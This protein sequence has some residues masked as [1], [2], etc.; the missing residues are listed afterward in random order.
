MSQKSSWSRLCIK[1]LSLSCIARSPSAP[2]RLLSI[3]Q[4]RVPN[5]NRSRQGALSKVV[6]VYIML[7]SSPSRAPWVAVRASSEAI[8]LI[9]RYR[10]HDRNVFPPPWSY[11]SRITTFP[12]SSVW[13]LVR[14][15]LH[16][17]IWLQVGLRKVNNL[18][19]DH[20]GHNHQESDHYTDFINNTSTADHNYYNYSNRTLWLS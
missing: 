7:M 6:G 14:E 16:D 18:F 4:Y 2:L 1:M 20:P 9:L 3:V 5:H 12:G 11:C 19:I 13:L 17:Q 10:H 15:A 8:T